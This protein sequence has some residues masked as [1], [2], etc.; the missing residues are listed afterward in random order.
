MLA[1]HGDPSAARA[2]ANAAVEVAAELGGFYPGLAYGALAVATLAAGDV[3]AADDAL[4][5]ARHHLSVLPKMAAIWIAYAAQ[6]A[7]AR[8]DLTAARRWADDAVATTTGWH[9][10]LPLTTRARVA[11]AQDEPEQ[12]DRDAHE[13][14]ATAAGTGAHTGAPDPLECLAALADDA[15]SHREAARLFG[16]ADAIRQR[17]GQVR[18][19]IHQAGYE[20]SVTAL[21]DGMGEKDFDSAWAEGE[22]RDRRSDRLRTAPSRR[23]QTPHQRGA[24]PTPTEREVV[25]L[26]GEGRANT[27]SPRGFSSHRAPCKPTSPTS[28]PNSASPPAY[29]SPRSSPPR[30]TDTKRSSRGL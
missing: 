13:A 4:A 29:N 1:Y 7:L 25:R 18:F 17:I 21:R 28:T 24:P 16:A 15:G 11:I 23:T 5:A 10:S 26:V 9:R 12:A 19:Q 8:G 30:L 14:L 20:A 2:T 27:T 3:A 6:T 22:A